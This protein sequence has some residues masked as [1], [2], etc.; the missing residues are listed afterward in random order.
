MASTAGN[1]PE[2]NSGE[3]VVRNEGGNTRRIGRKGVALIETMASEGATNTTIAKRLKINRDTLLEIRK[4]QPEVEE[5]LAR[6]RGALEDEL[7]DILLTKARKGETV[8]AIFLAKARC[9]WRE[10]DLP[11]GQHVTNNTQVNITMAPPMS[12]AEFAKLVSGT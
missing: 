2:T 8:A 7:T 4:R 9:G 5:A 3:I 1:S 10:G 6:G 11:P 12:D